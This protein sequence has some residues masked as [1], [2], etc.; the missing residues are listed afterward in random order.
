MVGIKPQ[1][2]LERSYGQLWLSQAVIDDAQ[3]V[4]S[5]YIIRLLLLPPTQR[6]R[7]QTRADF[8]GNRGLPSP[9]R[10]RLTLD[11]IRSF[12]ETLGGPA[13]CALVASTPVLN[14]TVR[15]IN[16]SIL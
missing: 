8:V 11:R 5:G 7:E 6:R 13:G 3:V 1:D 15:T 9:A 16:A 2:S 14:Q 12:D 10:P 4:A